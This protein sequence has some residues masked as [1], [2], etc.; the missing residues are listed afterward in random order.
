MLYYKVIRTSP[1]VQCKKYAINE[2][3]YVIVRQ[4]CKYTCAFLLQSSLPLAYMSGKW[5]LCSKTKYFSKFESNLENGI[6]WQATI[7]T[8]GTS[9]HLYVQL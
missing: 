2:G 4:I 7:G 3:Y 9:T 8:W 1:T 5:S 6:L